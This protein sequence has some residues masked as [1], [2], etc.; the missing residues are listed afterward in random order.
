MRSPVSSSPATVR[1]AMLTPEALTSANARPST[2]I[3]R[4]AKNSAM[5]L[6]RLRR[7]A[8]DSRRCPPRQ[9]PASA[10]IVDAARSIERK[11]FASA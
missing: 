5:R 1:L 9:R 2:A 6:C 7:R 3:N 8:A 4:I 10:I 11:Q